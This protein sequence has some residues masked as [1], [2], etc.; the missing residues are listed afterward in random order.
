[1]LTFHVYGE[2]RRVRDISAVRDMSAVREKKRMHI[3]IPVGNR[4]LAAELGARLKTPP[5]TG[6]PVYAQFT[7]TLLVTSHVGFSLSNH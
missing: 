2:K 3:S 5:N 4:L 7:Q 1:M 6:L